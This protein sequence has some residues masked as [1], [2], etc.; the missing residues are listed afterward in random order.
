MKTIASL[1]TKLAL[2]AAMFAALVAVPGNSPAGIVSF[3]SGSLIIPMDIG[4]GGQ[5]QGML[6]AY[7]LVY[8]LLR[9]GVPVSWAINPAKGANG[10][11]FAIVAAAA[12]RDVRTG[13]T[14]APRSYRGGPFVIAAADAGVALPIIQSWQGTAGDQTT[15]HQFVGS[16]SFNPNVDRLLVRAPRI[17][18]LKD[19]NETIAFNN[20]NAA[21]IR[22]SV[23]AFWTASSPDQLTEAD[24]EGPTTAIDHDGALLQPGSP[25]LAR[26][27]YLA[28]MHYIPTSH[29]DEVAQEVRFWLA[30]SNLA[31]LFAQCE[32]ARVFENAMGG[33]YLTNAG[34]DDDGPATTNPANRVPSSPLAQMDGVFEADSGAVDSMAAKPSG[35]PS[36][37][38]TGVSTI[39]NDAGSTPLQRIVLLT[40]RLDGVS[41]NGRVTYLAGHDYALGLPITSNP[42][43][44][45]VRLFL[46]SIFA[47]DVAATAEDVDLVLTKTAPPSVN[48]SEIPYTITYQN[49]ATNVHVAENIQLQDAIPVG[50]TYVNGSGVPT[51]NIDGATLT[52]NLSPLAPGQQATVTFRVAVTADRTYSNS[53]TLRFSTLTLGTVTTKPALTIHDTVAPTVTIT[54]GPLGDTSDTAP[55][56][57]FTTDSTAVTKVCSI[58]N[59]NFT[60][61][62]PGPATYTPATALFEGPHM[63]IVKVTDAT[64]N[65]A[66]AT[67]GFAVD[68]T[69]PVVTMAS[70]PT[71]PAVTNN[72]TP[73]F[74]F[75]TDDPSA[76]T[77]CSVA[78][79][80][81]VP[82][83][84]PFTTRTLSDGPYVVSVFARD[85]VA[86]VGPTATF[87]FVVDHLA[88]V[89]S[90]PVPPNVTTVNINR[91]IF[92]FADVGPSGTA[93]AY[94]C[95]ID[96]GASVFCTSPYQTPLVSDGTHTLTVTGTDAAGNTDEESL[97]FIVDT[98]APLVAIP[99]INPAS[100]S[101]STPTFVF[102][103]SN[104]PATTPLVASQCSVYDAAPPNAL[105]AQSPPG[106]SCDAAY[107]VP[108]T[109]ALSDGSYTFRVR[110]TDAAGNVGENTFNFV[111]DTHPPVVSIPVPPNVTTTTN[112]IPTFTFA[113]VA[114]PGTPVAF[115][116]R[117]DSGA[118]AACTSPFTV[119]A[120]LSD[121][122]HTLTVTGIDA[123]GNV[124]SASL[125]FSVI[126][127]VAPTFT[128]A[129]AATF[130][131][132]AAG[133]F[134]V[135]TNGSPRPTIS[136]TGALPAGVSFVPNANGGGTLSGTPTTGGT[137][138]ITFT[139]SNGTLP[140]ATQSF[141]LTVRK[142]PTFTS[143]NAATFTMGAANSFAVTTSGFPAATITRSG[144][145]PSGV[146]FVANANGTATLTGTP[147][148]CGT[149]PITFTAT[150]GVLPNATQSFTLTVTTP[151]LVSIEVTP[152]NPALP[153]GRTQ[154]FTATG[155]FSNGSH[156]DLTSTCA[157]TSSSTSIAIVSNA[158]GSKGLAT[159]KAPGTTQIRAL[160]GSISGSTTLSV[161]NA[162]LVAIQVTPVNS[163]I[164]AGGTRQ[165]SATGTFSDGSNQDLT[166][167]ANWTSSSPSAATVSNVNGSKG[168][169][170]GLAAGTTQIGAQSGTVLGT[171][172]L[173]VTAPVD[174]CTSAGVLDNFNRANGSLG[175][176]WLGLTGASFYAIKSNRIDVLVGGPV[177]WN[178]ASFGN[179]QRAFATLSTVDSASPS[180]G[181]LL[182]VQTGNCPQAGAIAVVYDATL[183]A[184]R[185]STFRP[186]N[187]TWTPYAS[188]SATL[189]NGDKLGAC[190]SATGVVTI[191]KNNVVA[192][193]VTLSAA[194]KAFFNSRGGKIGLWT[195]AANEASF[196]DFG[197]GTVTP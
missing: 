149:F 121:G 113:D 118:N 152:A 7:G 102:Q 53:A 12:L 107:T 26:Y 81:F 115:Q 116:C 105:K 109:N 48:T 67:R 140:N 155:T 42:Q 189:V 146:S 104:S 124:G 179:S 33:L 106:V 122:S 38:K 185:V 90:I 160:S 161:T 80:S 190:V 97:S 37:Y 88:P 64:G 114:G 93:V 95:R 86:N 1:N 197:G 76:T 47:T 141:T 168:L 175:S 196:D 85:A 40:G 61:C 100:V 3:G 87:A 30:S 4:P 130:T 170:T 132:G 162:V 8:E 182:K 59:V 154:Q 31:H 176:N 9:N 74:Y 83:T 177:F 145:L 142:A 131:V 188:A 129:N 125:A 2:L 187:L 28:V 98:I 165:F 89:I 101:T 20:L 73:R 66:Q 153:K 24:V 58:D 25:P 120:P 184:F 11:D 94:Q 194:D 147:T 91:P 138:P 18:V 96:A 32:G 126:T 119:P 163:T 69:S 143:A 75:T 156:Q 108:L 72:T 151:V 82:C 117:I 174:A 133:S 150:N 21:G 51:P 23:G 144:A 35:G 111:V 128:S 5:D 65:T 172:T 110:A 78:G 16:G 193:T 136:A 34:L 139:A 62:A 36:N 77:F 135:T 148:V 178:A 166:A 43:T 57:T 180:Q 99:P 41:T 14:L 17:A 22:D 92:T 191:Y 123:A 171:A 137:F 169:A 195:L 103:V 167:S 127:T 181:L 192:A 10:D 19:G 55:S 45:G 157:W 71:N 186:P 39:I 44:N 68:T 13:A 63:F 164:P 158:G 112:R 60:P 84:S 134:S 159:G 54:S 173:I 15:V 29:T 49:P 70:S 6:R 79:D 183:H 27:G 46:N 56:F 52:W 50:A